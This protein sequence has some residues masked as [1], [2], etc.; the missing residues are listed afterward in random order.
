MFCLHELM[1]ASH[2][3]WHHRC[4]VV[5]AAISEAACNLCNLPGPC[6]HTERELQRSLIVVAIP[7]GSDGLE[8]Q[9]P[10]CRYIAH[11]IYPAVDDRDASRRG[12]WHCPLLLQNLRIPPPGRSQ[13]VSVDGVTER[14]EHLG[15][16]GGELT[17]VGFLEKKVKEQ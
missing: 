3:L 15:G 17:R 16:P 2:L 1:N 7:V 12:R 9:E 5:Q 8:Q 14:G 4:G 10:G 11:L 6:L 13:I